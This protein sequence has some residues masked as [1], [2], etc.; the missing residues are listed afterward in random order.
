MMPLSASPHSV[1]CFWDPSPPLAASLIF[2][3]IVASADVLL[4]PLALAL[5]LADMHH[6]HIL[7]YIIIMIHGHYILIQ[8]RLPETQWSPGDFA[9]WLV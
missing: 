3:F 4:D 7:R 1:C 8:A 2:S 5:A 9:R 6:W